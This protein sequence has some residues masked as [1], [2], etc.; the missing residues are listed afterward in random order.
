MESYHVGHIQTGSHQDMKLWNDISNDS[1]VPAS[2]K[3]KPHG[4]S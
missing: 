2:G 1:L 3:K 4:T